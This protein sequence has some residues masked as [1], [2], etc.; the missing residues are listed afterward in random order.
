LRAISSRQALSFSAAVFWLLSS[1][2]TH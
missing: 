1:V 2:L